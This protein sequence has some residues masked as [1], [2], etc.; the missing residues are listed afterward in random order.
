MCSNQASDDIGGV[1]RLLDLF[2][3]RRVVGS[4]RRARRRRARLK[5]SKSAIASSIAS[6]VPEPIEKCAV[7]LAS[8]TSTALSFTQVLLVMVGKLRQSERLAISAW[9]SS[10]SANT[11]S[12]TGSISVSL[13]L[14]KPKLRQVSSSVS[15][16]Q[17]ERSGSYW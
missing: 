1:L 10:S 17:V 7:A 3:P 5:A 15:I 6:L 12:S 8:P 2:A 13:S 16:T 14:S 11:R 4:Q 9:P